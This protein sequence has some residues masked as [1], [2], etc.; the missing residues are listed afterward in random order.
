MRCELCRI[1]EFLI[2]LKDFSRV[3]KSWKT[4]RDQENFVTFYLSTY[5]W[6]KTSEVFLRLFKSRH[7]LQ[8]VFNL[9]LKIRINVWALSC[10]ST[11][12][13]VDISFV[14]WIIKFL[15]LHSS[16]EKRIQDSLL[17]S[18]S[19]V[20]VK[21]LLCIQTFCEVYDPLRYFLGSCLALKR[22]ET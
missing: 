15:S 18:R 16:L 3:N 1:C 22:D 14:L 6:M 21:M 11:R 19:Q 7:Q 12:F 20:F 8:L 2:I 5:K 10:Y 9:S 4:L 17:C 13:G